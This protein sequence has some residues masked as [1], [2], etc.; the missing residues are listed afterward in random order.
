MTV[1][2]FSLPVLLLDE[3]LKFVARNYADGKEFMKIIP[4]NHPG[5]WK[6]ALALLIGFVGYGYAWYQSEMALHGGDVT[7][8]AP[9]ASP[10]L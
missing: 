8:A 5:W 9:T 6:E 4:Q 7:P 10:T 2:K 1:M 3:A